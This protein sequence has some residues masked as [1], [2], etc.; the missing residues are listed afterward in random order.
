MPTIPIR[1]TRSRVSL[2]QKALVFSLSGSLLFTAGCASQRRPKF[3]IADAAF[4]RPI[5]PM[6]NSS[7]DG[8]PSAPEIPATTVVVPELS[9]V[10]T[11]P[12][13]PHVPQPANPQ[14]AR[15]GKAADP[16]IAPELSS[17]E[18]SVAKGDTQR[19]F[20]TVDRNLAL[21]QTKRL[22][23]AQ[24]DLVSQIRGFEQ[25]ARDASREGDWSRARNLAKK[26][27]VLSQELVGNL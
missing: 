18:L 1:P 3:R 8:K 15:T 4:A 6:E 20:D 26:A 17:E 22:N 11:L 13:R 27:E 24:A 16:V 10:R 12:T 23:S 5:M 2:C 9:V 14:P 19:S 7:V 25:S 21:A